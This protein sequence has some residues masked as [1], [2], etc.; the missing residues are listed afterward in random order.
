M[1]D[2][3]TNYGW[4]V[5]TIGGSSGAWGTLLNAVF[6]EIDEDLAAVEDLTKVFIGALGT[7]GTVTLDLTTNRYFTISPSGTVT[8]AFSN[9]P[10]GSTEATGVIVRLTNSGAYTI[11]W[12]AS[13]KWPGGT[14]PSFASAGTHLA[15]L[16][17]DDG[18]TTWRGN[19][20]LSFA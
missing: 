4:D 14:A 19:G 16:V 2:P 12:P 1:P 17:T 6:D 3:T 5:P 9:V 13:V 15:M 20:L 11:N 8:F 18:G 10:A 7:S